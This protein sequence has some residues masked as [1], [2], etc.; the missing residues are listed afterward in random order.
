MYHPTTRVLTVLELL[1]SRHR[2]TGSEIAQRLEVDTRTVRRY[3]AMLQELGI[4]VHAVRG[5]YGA[6]QLMP[7]FKLPPLMFSEDEALALTLGLLAARRLGL[8]LATTAAEGA[9]AKIERVLPA[10]LRARVQAVQEALMLDLVQPDAAPANA[11]V[12]TL[13]LAVQQSRCVWLRYHSEAGAET[14]RLID[15]YGLVYHAGRWYAP[16]YCHLREEM[17]LF[18]LDRVRVAELRDET[19]VRPVDFASLSYVVRSL[20][21]RPSIWSVRVLL[22]ATLEQA[23]RSVPAQ[24]A[25]VEQT[26]EGVE[27]HLQVE[28]LEWLARFLISLGFR[29]TIREPE[30]LRETL[31]AL[32]ADIVSMA[33]D[34]DASRPA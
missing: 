11:I 31:R 2:V 21:T 22:E 14:E 12:L 4:P 7:G 19:F 1:Q 17:R 3:I 34:S 33:S 8:T 20:A 27:L 28:D 5:R 24:Q 13:S 30:A 25:T 10:A 15:P 6:Y 18:R 32:A 16:A 29:F 26:A 9:L 23:R